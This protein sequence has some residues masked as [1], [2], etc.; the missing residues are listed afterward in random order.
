MG[1]S[2]QAIRVIGAVLLA[3]CLSYSQQPESTQQQISNHLHKAQS[4]LAENRTDLAIPELKAVVQLDPHN[5]GAIG[6][7]GVLLYFRGD[8]AD[9]IPDLRTALGLQPD[10]SRIQMLLGM[11]EKRQGDLPHALSDLEQAYPKLPDVHMRVD[12][13]LELVD[14]YTSTAHMEKAANIITQLR[15]DDPANQ[16]LMYVAYRLYS[17]LAS[18]SM[19]SLLLVAP[20]SAQTHAMMAHEDARQGND[21]AA[22]DEYKKALTLNS[23]LPGA[24]FELAELLRRASHDIQG[25]GAIEMFRSELETNPFDERAAC[26]LGDIEFDEGQFR[27]ARQDYAKALAIQ[28]SDPNATFG[29]AQTLIE[30]NDLAQGIPMLEKAVRLDPTNPSAHYRLARIYQRQGRTAEAQ[31]Q[32]K[33]FEDLTRLKQKLGDLYQAMRLEPLRQAGTNDDKTEGK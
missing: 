3:A 13:G 27:Q 14:L 15:H 6:N 8:Y 5:V 26:E 25:S 20:D 18:E 22:I 4:Y 17:D 1:S 19:L 30:T 33:E 29:M 24:K 11:A 21:A 16:Q 7:L 10:L 23:K 28:P 32:L 12:A 31:Q 2:R 9:A